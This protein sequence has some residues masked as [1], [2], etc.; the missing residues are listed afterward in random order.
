MDVAEEQ[1]NTLSRCGSFYYSTLVDTS[2]DDAEFV[3]HLT[4]QSKFPAQLQN[5]I[6]AVM[7]RSHFQDFYR[8]I[9]FTDADVNWRGMKAALQHRSSVPPSNPQI[10]DYNNRLP[11]Y[12]VGEGAALE[13]D[14][15]LLAD[16]EAQV[17]IAPKADS[18]IILPGDT[19]LFW[20]L[21]IDPSLYVTS[22]RTPEGKLWYAGQEYTAQ[23]G[24][25]TFTENPIKL[26][27]NMEL[28]AESCIVRKPHIYNHMLRLGSV[29]ETPDRVLHYYRHAQ[30]PKTFYLAAAQA[31]GM[32]VIRQDCT[33][34]NRMPLFDGYSYSTTAGIYEAPYKHTRLEPGTMLAEGYVIGGQELFQICG[35]NDALPTSVTA[36]DLGTAVPIPGLKATRDAIAI[37][38]EMGQYRPAYSGS[39]DALAAWYKYLQTI[40]DDGN[41]TGGTGIRHVYKPDSSDGNLLKP[42]VQKAIIA[43]AYNAGESCSLTF[44][45]LTAS[46][47]NTFPL[48]RL[49]NDYYLVS[50]GGSYIG[51][52]SSATA[53]RD[54]NGQDPGWA[55]ATV[56]TD[57]WGGS[58]NKFS[59]DGRIYGWISRNAT[60]ATGVA[61]ALP[62]Q[63]MYV[64]IQYKMSAY[65][66][67]GL[68]IELHDS[69]YNVY[70]ILY[71][72]MGVLDLDRIDT[73]N[74]TVRV[75]NV[76][77][78]DT[79]GLPVS[80]PGIDHFRNTA[81]ANR[82]LVACINEAFMST[83]MQLRLME[84]LRRE[85]PTGSVLVTADLPVVVQD[86][87]DPEPEPEPEP[88]PLP[89]LPRV[90]RTVDPNGGDPGYGG[91]RGFSLVIPTTAACFEWITDAPS[92]KPLLLANLEMECPSGTPATYTVKLAAYNARTTEFLGVSDAQTFEANTSKRFHFDDIQVPLDDQIVFVFV[93]ETTSTADLL[94]PIAL[95]LDTDDLEDG[96]IATAWRFKV[97][98]LGSAGAPDKWGLVGPDAS[99]LIPSG[100]QPYVPVLTLR[101]TQQV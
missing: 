57:D 28:M 73:G 70:E 33:I 46:G 86:V 21:N 61:N 32:A 4:W 48:L 58:I 72:N 83:E 55:P 65:D 44:T 24:K 56:E 94:N 20:D 39:P 50:Q 30:T 25:L 1:S 36:I 67:N 91:W 6:E 10:P 26:F 12:I 64:D 41:S 27:P 85:L 96:M 9:K 31:C 2:K 45:V 7:G 74:L 23:Y 63:N 42:I 60:G 92:D 71:M 93:K 84:F 34:V 37:W 53:M 99:E 80:E 22:I 82:C 40:N 5:I 16:S 52:S 49:A 51:L 35:P 79:I 100:S 62:L 89:P 90:A 38:N 97:W 69:A 13:S 8:L 81:C 59:S 11:D 47:N 78:V 43:N 98:N 77:S 76:V 17:I 88:E 3:S 19:Q 54:A 75:A 14:K 68:Y 101:F 29:Y 15:G 87:V 95:G 18:W 66:A